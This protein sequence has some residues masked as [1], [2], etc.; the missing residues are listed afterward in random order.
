MYV[1]TKQ[2]NELAEIATYSRLAFVAAGGIILEL[3][4]ISN[5]AE[6]QKHFERKDRVFEA[7]ADVLSGA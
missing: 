6:L 2:I 4:F 5:D 1:L 3:F 7:I